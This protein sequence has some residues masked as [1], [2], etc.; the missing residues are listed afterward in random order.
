MKE[1]PITLEE[2]WSGN[3]S[4]VVEAVPVEKFD[5]YNYDST[6]KLPREVI[7]GSV[8]KVYYN[9]IIIP[10]EDRSFTV[11]Y[12]LNGGVY[13]AQE[14]H[15]E[16]EKLTLRGT[17]A[18]RTGQ[19][20][21]GW[22]GFTEIMPYG[23]VNIYGTITTPAPIIPETT[24]TPK[25]TPTPTPTPEVVI[26]E[27]P[28]VPQGP[29]GSA[30]AW[31]LLNLILTIVTSIA[32]LVLLVGYYTGKKKNE[33]GSEDEDG[34]KRKGLFRILSLIPALTAIIV[35]IFTENMANPMVFTDKFTPIMI[36]IAVV[37]A[38]VCL[39]SIKSEKEEDQ[40][41]AKA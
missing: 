28:D 20:F 37:Q 14:Y 33:D 10:V 8:I 27:E 24:P 11:T 26:V 34:L 40:G 21:S 32:S 23:D 36:I 5:H 31:A 35:F 2:L 30:A 38:V 9:K 25:P 16:G 19:T 13:G 15:K 6:D 3:L 12:Y 39:L 4:A 17:P 41:G 7:D 1:T 22:H 18:L 29:G